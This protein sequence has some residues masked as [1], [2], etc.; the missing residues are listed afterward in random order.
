[1]SFSAL[2]LPRRCLRRSLPP[3]LQSKV[4]E[5]EKINDSKV[6]QTEEFGGVLRSFEEFGRV[7]GNFEEF[8]GVL[9][10]LGEFL[11]VLEIWDSV[12]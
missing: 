3:R 9:K 2:V 12:N 7:L 10:S 11:G 1:M 8:L 6:S 5:A 4:A